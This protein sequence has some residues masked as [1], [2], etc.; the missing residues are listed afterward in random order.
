MGGIVS[1]GEEGKMERAYVTQ[2]QP[3]TTGDGG[4]GCPDRWKYDDAWAA[5]G[6]DEGAM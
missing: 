2:W 5:P 6:G 3:E 4:P 1:T